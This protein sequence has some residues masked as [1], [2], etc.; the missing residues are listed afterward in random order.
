MININKLKKLFKKKPIKIEAI[1][2]PELLDIRAKNNTI[3]FS[4]NKNKL[5][6]KDVTGIVKEIKL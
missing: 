6:Y 1:R 5:V 3:Y 4:L 2:V